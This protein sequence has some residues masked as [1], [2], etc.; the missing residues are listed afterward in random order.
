MAAGPYRSAKKGQERLKSRRK[1]NLT[2]SIQTAARTLRMCRLIRRTTSDRCVRK[3]TC[4]ASSMIAN[5]ASE[6]APA[7][8]RCRARGYDRVAPPASTRVGAPM[9]QSRS[10]MSND[11]SCARRCGHH[12]LAGFPDTIDH[13]VNQRAR[14][15]LDAEEKVEK[16][17]DEAT[18]ARKREPLEYPPGD[19]GTD[20]RDETAPQLRARSTPQAD[21]DTRPPA[22]E[23]S[24]RRTR[25]RKRQGNPDPID[26]SS[27]RHLAHSRQLPGFA[28]P[29]FELVP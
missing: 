19:L 17:V 9:L 22:P 6:I 4:P 3:P 11:S 25:R 21:R 10:E 2:G 20:R 15:W 1:P 14:L 27:R 28:R 18:V 12:A 29:A 13:K 7:S 8:A 26:R 24:P 23:R 16:L 5:W